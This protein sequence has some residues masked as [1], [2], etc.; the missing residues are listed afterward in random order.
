MTRH[1]TI[2]APLVAALVLLACAGVAAAEAVAVA[3]PSP[4]PLPEWAPSYTAPPPQSAGA[5][6]FLDWYFGPAGAITSQFFEKKAQYH[7][8][9]RGTLPWSWTWHVD[10][11]AC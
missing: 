7:C 11:A 4:P 8:K 2:R 5:N 1:A 10:A 6:A 3:I 9:R